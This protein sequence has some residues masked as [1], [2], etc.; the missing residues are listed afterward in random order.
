MAGSIRD[1]A[2]VYKKKN[3]T[4]VPP[5]PPAELIDST[6]YTLDF[7]ARK[8][9]N[10][11]FDSEDK[12][13]IVIHII[14]PS[15]YVSIYEGFLRR[16]FSLMG[17]ILSF[18]LDVPQKYRKQIFLEDEFIAASNMVYRG[19]NVLVIESKKK[20][21]CRVLL[22]RKNLMKLQYIE[23]I[24]FET[25][26]RKSTIIRPVV[27]KQFE[28]I[29]NYIDRELTN[30]LSPPKTIEEMIIFIK[31][32]RADQIIKNIDLNFVSQ[33][34]MFAAPKLAEQ[35][36]RWSREMSPELFVDP[37]SSMSPPIIPK[38]YSSPSPQ[39]NDDNDAQP[40]PQQSFSPSFF[41]GECS[42]IN[43]TQATYCV[44]NQESKP[45]PTSLPSFDCL[46][47]T[48]DGFDTD[49]FAQYPPWYNNRVIHSPPSI[50]VDENDGPTPFNKSPSILDSKPTKKRSAKRKLFFE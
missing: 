8:F 12:F 19:E 38:K 46:D 1:M 28:I 27:L 36:L 33:L 9:L 45:K 15:R 31:N 30:V 43:P 48:A 2:V 23:E 10:V 20:E 34:K 25:I 3:F 40:A 18:I 49:N 29:G 4:Y 16:I 22:D 50:A 41:D 32:L 24:I 7:V 44:Q 42:Q 6:S 26:A 5:T 35:R 11:G 39:Y 21:G 37:I 14:T 17:N 13:K 47:N